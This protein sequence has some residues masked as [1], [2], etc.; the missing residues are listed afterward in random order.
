MKKFIWRKVQDLGLACDYHYRENEELRLH[1]RICASFDGNQFVESIR[2]LV[3]IPTDASR[4]IDERSYWGPPDG[5]LGPGPLDE[6]SDVTFIVTAAPNMAT[7]PCPHAAAPQPPAS[8]SV[9]RTFFDHLYTQC[10]D[11]LQTLSCAVSVEHIA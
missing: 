6:I 7:V 4:L 2:A 3:T 1:C 5:R 8:D 10:V 11:Y 9:N